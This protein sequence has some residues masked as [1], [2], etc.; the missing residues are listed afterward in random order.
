MKRDTKHVQLNT[1]ESSL[2]L[3]KITIIRRV[4]RKH[5][6]IEFHTRHAH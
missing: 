3:K 5:L 4:I 1:Q 6:S 2:V